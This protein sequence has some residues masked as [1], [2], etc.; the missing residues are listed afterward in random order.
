MTEVDKKGIKTLIE[1]AQTLHDK[2]CDEIK[3][4][5]SFCRVCSEHGRYCDVAEAPLEER[6]RLIALTDSLKQVEN[7]RRFLQSVQTWQSMDRNAALTRLENS[8]LYLMEQVKGYQGKIDVVKELNVCF[9]NKTLLSVVIPK[10]IYKLTSV[11]IMGREG[12]QV[13]S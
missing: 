6:E 1:R 3:S 8:R 7:I 11:F 13:F 4:S 5:I 2:L 9:G 12:F 10:K